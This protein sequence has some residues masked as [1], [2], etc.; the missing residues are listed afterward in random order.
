M[1][2]LSSHLA[3]ENGGKGISLLIASQPSFLRITQG[4]F[5][6]FFRSI[7]TA[8]VIVSLFTG[9]EGVVTL[10]ALYLFIFGFSEPA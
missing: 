1:T 5:I 6:P 3:S 2:F 4:L 7:L 9:D 10:A 8:Q